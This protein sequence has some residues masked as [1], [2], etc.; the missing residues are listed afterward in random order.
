MIGVAELL[1]LSETWKYFD[2]SECVMI[3][4]QKYSRGQGAAAYL[5]YKHEKE[6]L[7]AVQSAQ[8]PLATRALKINDEEM[9]IS[10]V[11]GVCTLAEVAAERRRRKSRWKETD[12]LYV[13]IHLITH[14]CDLAA[15][16]N[17]CHANIKPQNVVLENLTGNKYQVRLINFASAVMLDVEPYPFN[18]TQAYMDRRAVT[19]TGV[20]VGV[21]PGL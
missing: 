4:V 7:S 11:G 9:L 2:Q 6:V 19:A 1:P 16:F 14:V 10:Y 12:L 5:N 15:H 21:G 18:V 20:G 8:F 3:Y 17:V 13:M